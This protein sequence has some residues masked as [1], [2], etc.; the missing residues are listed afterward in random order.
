MEGLTKRERLTNE[1]TQL[2]KELELLSK[3]KHDAET[4]AAAYD[5][6]IQYQKLQFPTGKESQQVVEQGK[7]PK[8]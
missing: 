5:G 4:I 8:D 3:L 7:L 1:S 2:R 6:L